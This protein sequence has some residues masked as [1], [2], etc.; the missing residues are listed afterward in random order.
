[1]PSEQEELHYSDWYRLV[2]GLMH[3][4]PLGQVVRIRSE[5][6]KDIIK[7][8]GPYEN[9]IRSEWAEF[10]ST[11]VTEEDKMEVANYF[12]NLFRNMFGGE[13]R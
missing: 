3:D 1:M 8:F 13:N 2:A 4:T 7:N 9:R 5:D 11:H 6:D 12:N 10:R